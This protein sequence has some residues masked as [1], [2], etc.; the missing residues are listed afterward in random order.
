MINYPNF[1]N[2]RVRFIR[3]YEHTHTQTFFSLCVLPPVVPRAVLSSL[4]LKRICIR[5][6]AIWRV[7]ASV[8][9]NLS[10]N[11]SSLLFVIAINI[12]SYSAIWGLERFSLKRAQGKYLFGKIE[13][14]T[15]TE[16]LYL[17]IWMEP[18]WWARPLL[19]LQT[20]RAGTN[21]TELPVSFEFFNFLILSLCS[22]PQTNSLSPAFVSPEVVVSQ[23]YD[24]AAAD[25]WAVGVILYILLTGT[26]PFRDSQ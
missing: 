5:S 24:G 7:C 13:S 11:P 10:S 2:W 20:A 25:M 3:S 12:E 9:R 8:M 17:L 18:S 23:S 4:R 19:F 15:V 1:F 16:K 26:Y 6:H 21:P 14:N 22:S